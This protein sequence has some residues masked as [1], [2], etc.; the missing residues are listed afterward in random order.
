DPESYDGVS[1]FL[2]VSENDGQS[3]RAA[4]LLRERLYLVKDRSLH[5][6]EDD[7]V[8]EP[9]S[10][11]VNQVSKTVGTL[12]VAGVDTGEDWAVIAGRAGIYIFDGGEPIKISQ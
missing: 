2:S 4:F 11:T 1:G 10:W 8:N 7:G 12:S 5:V 3:V 9:A 6:T